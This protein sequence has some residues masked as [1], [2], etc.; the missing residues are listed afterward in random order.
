[1]VGIVKNID[2]HDFITIRRTLTLPLCLIHLL[3]VD[4][5]GVPSCFHIKTFPPRILV[6]HR[7]PLPKKQSILPVSCAATMD[8]FYFYFPGNRSPIDKKRHTATILQN[9][10]IKSIVFL[11]GDTW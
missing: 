6:V 2:N 7:A 11:G 1:M 10:N 9:E 4:H 3:D 8:F 5:H